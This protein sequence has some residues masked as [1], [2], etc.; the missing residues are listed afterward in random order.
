MTDVEMLLWFNDAEVN[1]HNKKLESFFTLNCC[2]VTTSLI[3]SD[4]KKCYNL[5]HPNYM[6]C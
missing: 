6:K 3:G 1:Y 2:Q 4:R 5:H